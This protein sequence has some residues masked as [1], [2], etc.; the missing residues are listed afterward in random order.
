MKQTAE[1]LRRREGSTYGE[2]IP[3]DRT[4]IPEWF[5]T[6]LKSWAGAAGME[7]FQEQRGGHMT[8]VLGGKILVI[9]IDLQVNRAI[10]DNP[11]LAIS[12]LKTS[13]AVPNGSINSTTDGSTSLDTS[14][15]GT[16]RA[17]LCEVQKDEEL[18][19]IIV[20]ARHGA[21]FQEHLKYLMS[22]DKLALREGDRGLRWFNGI[23]RLAAQFI[24]PLAIKEADAI[25][26]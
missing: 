26:L 16:L 4:A 23:D 9:D 21:R 24:E 12:A 25:A 10:P 8:V 19:D 14:L 2:D 13:F 3:L 15:A 18:Q 20:A 11:I 1:A 7:T 6:R 17:F 22:L 5:V